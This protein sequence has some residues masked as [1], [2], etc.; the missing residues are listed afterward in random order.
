MTAGDATSFRISTSVFPSQDRTEGF[1]ETFGRAMFQVEIEPLTRGE[2]IDADM[3]MRVFP[4]L[5]IADGPDEVHRG[6]V[7]K[8]E[9]MKY[10]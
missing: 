5:R 1:R 4:V 9:L 2:Q 7:A 3:T 8:F 6:L 10:R